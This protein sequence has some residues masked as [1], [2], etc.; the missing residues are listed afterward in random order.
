[1]KNAAFLTL[2]TKDFIKGFIVSVLTVVMTGAM[3]SLNSGAL[4]TLAE[5]KVLA[6]TGLGAGVAYIVKNLLTNSED[7]FMKAEPKEGQ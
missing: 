7:K 4:P 3:T 5:V 1:M 2:K 6:L